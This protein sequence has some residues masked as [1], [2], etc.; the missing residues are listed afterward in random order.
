[1]PAAI[2]AVLPQGTVR[3]NAR[4][5]AIASEPD[6]PV[7]LAFATPAGALQMVVDYVILTLPF[8][9]LRVLD[10]RYA[11]L[12]ALKLADIRELAY[13]TNS[14][15]ILQFDQRYWNQRGPWGRR[16]RRR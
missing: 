16:R 8:S 1:M 12:D 15:L 2:A 6:G 5:S 9:V 13:G 7:T 10:L 3:T 4:L 14:K 11:G